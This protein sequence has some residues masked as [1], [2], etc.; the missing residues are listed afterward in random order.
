MNVFAEMIHAV[1]DFKG[2]GRFLKN[3]KAKTFL[4]GLLLSLI[5]AFVSLIL[6]VAV[7]MPDGGT[8]QLIR[9]EVPDFS[10]EDGKLW[11]AKPV[12]YSQYDSVQGGVYILIN[13][14][15]PVTQEISDIDLVAFEKAVV[16]DEENILLKT[17]GEIVRASYSDFDLGS[18]DRDTLFTELLPLIRAALWGISVLM[19]L[20]SVIGFFAGALFTA[21]IG[22]VIRAVW[23]CSLDFGD[24]FKLAVHARTVPMLIKMVLAWFP[25]WIPFY[26]VVNFGI[27]AV[28]MWRA[29]LYLGKEQREQREKDSWMGEF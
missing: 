23:K 6:P 16:M 1:Y 21:V 5:C 22:V 2:Y 15:R 4:Y 7:V 19:V 3:G 12:E 18:W 11:F 25:V 13:T 24:L 14:D 20:F 17:N 8:E 27:S 26:L 9:E 28:Y 29:I 10:L